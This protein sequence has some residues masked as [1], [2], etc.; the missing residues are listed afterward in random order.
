MSLINNLVYSEFINVFTFLYFGIYYFFF[1]KKYKL[2]ILKLYGL[3][4][5]KIILNVVTRII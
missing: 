5:L 4:K 2:I 1:V 3:M